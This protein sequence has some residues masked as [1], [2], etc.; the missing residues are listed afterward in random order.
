MT[1]EVKL[2]VNG[3][4]YGGWLSVEITAGIERQSRDFK[5]GI[6]RTWPGATEIPRMVKPFDLCEVYIGADKVLTGFVDST[7]ISYNDTSV[8][9]GVNGRSKTADMVDCAAD[10]GS[11][12]WRNRKIE[13]IATDIAKAYGITVIAEADTGPAIADHQIDTGE[14]AYESIGR[15]LAIRQ[16]LSTDDAE[17]RMI[18]INAG[19]GGRCVT[20]L[21]YG[22][23]DGNILSADAQLDYK[24]VFSTYV[25]K[26]QRSGNDEDFAETVSGMSASMTDIT[27]PRNRKL[28]IQ[29]S[30][31]VT[32]LDCS[33]RVQYERLYRAAKA[34]QTTYTVKGWRQ[35]DGSLWVP[36]K[37]VRVI[38]P[39]IG[40][41]EELLIVEVT[42][43]IDEQGTVT[44]LS[45]APKGGFIPSPEAAKAKKKTASGSG[46]DS[47][48]DVKAAK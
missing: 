37:T 34:V 26:G 35:G 15:M 13:R 8:T 42:Y 14:S 3:K 21:K 45:V 17:G 32:Q 22:K 29:Q 46:G 23:P 43:K 48:S 11:G 47:W 31:Q 38:D 41:D 16:L 2:R 24:D 6:T 36:N 19:S 9:V 12:Q 7:P 4:D 25:C 20:S 33:Q 10:Y 27:V 40:F 44:S 30:G 18:L 39:V 28:I 1:D 5:L